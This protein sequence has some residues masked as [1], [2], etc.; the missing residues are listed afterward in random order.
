MGTG[1]S[2]PSNSME[3]HNFADNV[4]ARTVEETVIKLSK[5]S[6]GTVEIMRQPS[7][8]RTMPNKMSSLRSFALKHHSRQENTYIPQESFM[9]AAKGLAKRSFA[10]K[11][12][13]T[14]SKSNSSSGLLDINFDI[15]ATYD[16]NLN[17]DKVKKKPILKISLED[18]VHVDDEDWIQ[19][20]ELL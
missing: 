7:N 14:S 19:V 13:L 8:S 4:V 15:D 12:A 5:T 18:A 16:R 9:A 20:N 6:N 1:A 10:G 3:F 11:A 2:V 17:I